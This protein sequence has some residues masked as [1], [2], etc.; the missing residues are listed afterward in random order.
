MDPAGVVDYTPFATALIPDSDGDGNLDP[1]DADDDNDGLPDGSDNCPTVANP[2]QA[3]FDGDGIGDAC[4][5]STLIR[6]DLRP[7]NAQNQVNTAS[8]QLVPIAILGQAGF[9]PNTD[10]D[11]ESVLVRGASPVATKFDEND[12]NGDGFADLTLYFRARDM[13]D[14]SVIECA[15]PNAMILLTGNFS[16][17]GL[18]FEGTDDV[19]WLN[20]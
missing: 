5:P 9:D 7:N 12:V 19:T 14:P 15:D 10:V 18:P 8:K 13:A 11:R 16:P 4:D 20:C 2:D 3:D 17:S 1:C 6:I